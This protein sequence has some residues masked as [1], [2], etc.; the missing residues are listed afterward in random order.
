MTYNNTIKTSTDMLGHFVCCGTYETYIGEYTGVVAPDKYNE[1]DAAVGTL[2]VEKIAEALWDILPYEVRDEFECVYTSTY[3]P[4]Y[5]NFK[6]DAANFDFNYSDELKDWMLNYAKENKVAFDKFLH[7]NYTSRDG[8]ISFT[9]NNFDAWIC[10]WHENDNRCVSALLTYMLYS[11]A[12]SD[13]YQH[14]FDER[15]FY[16]ITENYVSYDYAVKYDNG[17]TGVCIGEYDGGS[18][19]MFT[20]YLLDADGNILSTCEYD[21]EYDDDFKMSAYAAW[22]FGDIERDVT[23]DFMDLNM[24]CTAKLCEV[25][26]IKA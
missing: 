15:V 11:D 22:E 17:Y 9:P 16:L 21:D 3:H 7:D 10:D 2:A 12:D 26:E 18:G 19:T 24:R 13:D 1:M 20:G 6:T 8:F 5:Y 23:K 25:P 14:D 4:Q